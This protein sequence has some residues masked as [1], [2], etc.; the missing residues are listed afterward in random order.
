LDPSEFSIQEARGHLAAP[1][2]PAREHR[3]VLQDLDSPETPHAVVWATHALYCVPPAELPTAIERMLAA[4]DP[5]GL[6]FV[7]HAS[8]H[9]HYLRFQ[10]LHV[11]HRR[12]GQVEPFS[13][14]EQV[15][16][17]LRA[18]PLASRALSWTIDYE[19]VLDIA[20][21]QTAERYLQRCLF[22]ETLT[23]NQMLADPVMG[24]YLDACRDDARGVWR[25]PQRTWL[26]F[27]GE[28]AEHVPGCRQSAPVAQ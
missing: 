25:F 3:C 11:E 2:L 1:F 4:V 13:S 26:F 20:D 18:H 6:G 5:R 7:A 27:W 8:Q 15:I 19:G 22:D 12:D 17:A 14:G 28:S 9:S 10:Q 23:L 24:P 21:H 16:Q